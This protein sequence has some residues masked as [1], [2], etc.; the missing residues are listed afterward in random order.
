MGKNSHVM[1]VIM[2]REYPSIVRGK[3]I[4]MYDEQGK[5][6]IDAAGGPILCSLGYGLEEMGEVLKKQACEIAFAYRMYSK[7]PVLEKAADCVYNFSKGVLDKVFFVSGGTEATEIA[8]KIARTYHVDNGQPQRNKVIGRWLSYHGNTAGALSW[9]GHVARRQLFQHYLKDDGHIAP[10]YCYRCWYNK[11]PESCNIECA[12]S[13]EDEILLQGPETVS[14]FIVEPV[15]GN[16]LCAAVPHPDYFRRIREICDRYGVLLILDEVMTGIGRTGRNF[17]Y[18]HFG[19]TPDIIALGKALSGGYF[20]VG[21]AACTEKIADTIASKSGMFLSGYSWAGNPL[22]AAVV[23]KNIE[24]LGE[25][26]LVNCVAELGK[27]VLARFCDL[28]SHPSVGDVRGLGLMTG[29]E[30]VKDRDTK[31]CFEPE[32]HYY[33]QVVEEAYKHGMFIQSGGGN[34]KGKCGDMAFIGPAYIITKE[35]IDKIADIF[36][37][38]ITKVEKRNGF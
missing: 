5:T 10:A 20:P 37:S 12:Q 30:F 31:E 9:G 29:I 14:A 16:S 33:I 32:R 25:R 23:V 36:D 8:V 1:D 15:S 17:A 4:Y 18:E 27:Y 35:E 13:L 19:I 21:A 26:E 24:I 22:A 38:V 11:A 7:T 34:V 28:K 6:Y 3:G 2:N